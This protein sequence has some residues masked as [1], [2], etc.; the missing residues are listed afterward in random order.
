SSQ[1]ALDPPGRSSGSVSERSYRSD[2][3]GRWEYQLTVW[4][5]TLQK[6]YRRAGLAAAFR[7]IGA[8]C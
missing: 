3:A 7:Y 1:P 4:T 6:A 5:R 8:P 2:A